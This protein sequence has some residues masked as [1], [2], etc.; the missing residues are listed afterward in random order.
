V[1]WIRSLAV[2]GVLLLAGWVFRERLLNAC[3]DV[4]VAAE[5]PAHA[6]MI[7][8]LAGDGNGLRILTAAHLVREGYAPVALI[9]GPNGYYETPEC[10]VA[11][12]FATKR[13]YPETYFRHFHAHNKSTEEEAHDIIGELRKQD[14]KSIL[15]V[16]SGYHTRRAG[17]YYKHIPGIEARMI[18]APDR[19]AEHGTWWK[20]REGR[21]TVF[22]E[23]SKTIAT[24]AGL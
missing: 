8:V 15:V 20:E 13:G 11:I 23:W 6:D 14:V 9:S 10:D 24:V 16:T 22:F 21:K 2:I 18:A 3:F 17:K 7:V 19:Y 12:P 5:K 1:K 4:L